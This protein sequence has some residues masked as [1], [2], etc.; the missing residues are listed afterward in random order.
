MEPFL[1]G[2]VG[3]ELISDEASGSAAI[4]GGYQARWAIPDDDERE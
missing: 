4:H 3:E 2:V 1:F